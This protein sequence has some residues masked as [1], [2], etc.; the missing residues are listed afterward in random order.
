MDIELDI[1]ALQLYPAHEETLKTEPCGW[2]C[3]GGTCSE[4]CTATCS[5]TISG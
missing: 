1:D 2:S 5:V 3:Q 4:T